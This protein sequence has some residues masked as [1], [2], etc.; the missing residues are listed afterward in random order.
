MSNTKIYAYPMGKKFD[1][2]RLSHEI[3]AS[4]VSSIIESPKAYAGKVLVEFHESLTVEQETYLDGIIDAH[5]GTLPSRTS[6]ELQNKRELVLSELVDM[7]HNHPV[8]KNDSDVI[9]EYLTSIDNWFNSWKRDGNHNKIVAKIFEDSQD[10]NHPNHGFLNT[11]VR[12]DGALTYQFLISYI[13]T[14][15]YI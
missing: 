3:K 4:P 5:D 10:S 1:L 11:I 14:N 6:I 8:L 12:S 13:P 15:P 7:A 9:T 2:Q